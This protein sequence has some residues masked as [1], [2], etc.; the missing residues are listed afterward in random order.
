MLTPEERAY[1][2]QLAAQSPPLTPEQ[3]RRLRPVLAGTL[4]LPAAAEPQAA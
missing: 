4:K 2:E 1:L 3:R